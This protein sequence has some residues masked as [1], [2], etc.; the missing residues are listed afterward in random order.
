MRDNRKTGRIL[1][2]V[3]GILSI[4]VGGFVLLP[5]FRAPLEF[6]GLAETMENFDTIYTIVA[7]TVIMGGLITILGA[8][9]VG[10]IGLKK[11]GIIVLIGSV[12]SGVNPLSLIGSVSLIGGAR[13]EKTIDSRSGTTTKHESGTA[14]D[15]KSGGDTTT[16]SD[17]NI[18]EN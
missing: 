15:I 9:L 7:G 13:V 18:N 12:L 14:E 2:Y 4:V 11:G 17:P 16:K 3:G 10:N 1:S 8:S 5:K 6:F